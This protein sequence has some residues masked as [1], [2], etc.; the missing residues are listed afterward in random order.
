MGEQVAE[1]FV[2]TMTLGD[3]VGPLV[4]GWLVQVFGFPFSSFL[5]ALIPVP[6]V[7]LGIASYDSDVIRARRHA[8]HGEALHF[9]GGQ[10]L[11]IQA[12]EE[13][14]GALTKRSLHCEG[15]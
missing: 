12:A 15:S 6:L 9:V 8:S 14:Q 7:I 5:L 11:T 3:V 10:M 2:L 4:G 1:L 13:L